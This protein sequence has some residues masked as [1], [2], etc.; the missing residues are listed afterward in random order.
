MA[1]TAAVASDLAER[2]AKQN[3]SQ[4][5][6]AFPTPTDGNADIDRADFLPPEMSVTYLLP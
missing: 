4:F 2:V 6:L 5:R 1:V 3:R